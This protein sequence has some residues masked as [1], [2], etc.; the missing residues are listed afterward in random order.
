M[1]MPTPTMFASVSLSRSQ[2]ERLESM[3]K[4]QVQDA[5]LAR[6]VQ[7]SK[8]NNLD[9]E[10]RFVNSLG[11]LKTFRVR[12]TDSFCSTSSW[13]TTLNRS[14]RATA[15]N[16]NDRISSSGP[17]TW[18]MRSRS[19]VQSR[20]R[21]LSFSRRTVGATL[22]RRDP[23]DPRP[24]LQSFRTFG[25]VQG[26]YR[27]IVDAHYAS[28]S[29]DFVRQQRLLSPVVIDGAVLHTI[30]AT[31]DSYLGIKWLAENSFTGKRDVCF[32]EM[33]GYTTNTTGQEIGFVAM[34]SVDVPECPELTG[35]MKLTRVRMKRTMLVAPSA[36]TPKGTSEVFVMGASET[37]ESSII[38]HAQYRFNMAVLNDIS[39]V[40]DSQN[41]AKQTLALHKNWVPDEN[42]PS[43]SICSRK[44]H[45]MYR[46][47]HHCRLC[48]DVVCKTC[49]VTRAVP[50]A[51]MEEGYGCKPA[52]NTVICQTKFCVRCVMGLRAM[53]KRLNKFSQQISKMLSLNVES[54]N[55][56]RSNVD[57][58]SPG[59]NVRDS[60]VTY[61]KRGSKQKHTLDL[62]QLY[63]MSA[64]QNN[65]PEIDDDIETSS[66]K[67]GYLVSFG[68][69]GS[70]YFR[71]SL[72]MDPLHSNSCGKLSRLSRHSSAAS[73][74]GEPVVF[75]EKVVLN[76]NKLSRIV[77]I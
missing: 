13:A 26:N 62:D 57:N 38:A 42:R 41:I 12:G 28:N 69:G 63:K 34:A 11:Q 33:V 55:M 27:D 40:I 72:S 53:D 5:V 66:T 14:N 30:R 24:P 54:L 29:V 39:L 17:H 46:R 49:Y 23:L 64:W 37:N 73:L 36:D 61:Y 47:R 20:H 21:R 8:D 48:G 45:F 1:V 3:M 43:C 51:N 10:W 71:P 52:D 60:F 31:K 9:S 58:Q 22:G 44:F 15:C 75:E 59:S 77:A 2:A 74:G 18:A 50:G 7:L 19:S 35:S 76:M 56:S 25:R 68:S 32:V 67:A 70:K 6:T 16:V 4:Q 65:A